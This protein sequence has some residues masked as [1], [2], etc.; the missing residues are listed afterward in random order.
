MRGCRD[1]ARTVARWSVGVVLVSWRYL[2]STTPLHRSTVAGDTRDWPPPLDE[3]FVDARSQPVARGVGPLSHRLFTVTIVGARLNAPEVVAEV[4]ADLNRYVPGEAASVEPL[5]HNSGQL[6][7]GEELI[8]RIPG[9][10]NG[11]VRVVHRDAESFRFATLGGHL[12]AG[13]I[14]FRARDVGP[15]LRFEIETWARPG[16]RLVNL[17]YN[18]LWFASEVQ[19]NMWVRFCLAATRLSG[20]RPQ[21]GVTIRTRVLGEPDQLRRCALREQRSVEVGGS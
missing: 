1:A 15:L 2:W 7:V 16:D 6:H 9:P 3:R 19:L 11:P 8:V 5:G 18:R 21:D 14:E 4:A 10:W 12:E 17:L 20:G 13:Q